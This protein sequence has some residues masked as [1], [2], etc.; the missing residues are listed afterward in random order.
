MTGQVVDLFAGPGGWDVAAHALGMDVI[1][2]ELDQA[3]CDTRR[4][5]GFNTLQASVADLDP[6]DFRPCDG[7]IAS[8][9][10]QA[11]SSAGKRGG[12][13][14]KPIV[15][16]AARDIVTGDHSLAEDLARCEDPRSLL[17]V[18]PLRWALALRPRWLAFEQV[19]PVLEFWRYIAEFLRAAGYQVWTGLLSSERY[20]VAQT[21]R[22]AIL[23]ASL[24]GPVAPPAPTHQAYV[25]GEPAREEITLEGVLEPWVSMAEAL[26][27]TGDGEVN[28]RRGGDR[29]DESVPTGGPSPTLTGRF[30]RWQVG[31]PRLADDGAATEDGYRE[32]DLRGAGEP[33][34]GM[35]E[36]V[37]SWTVIDTG[38]TSGGRNPGGARVRDGDEPA[39]PLTSRADQLE[40]RT[41]RTNNFSAKRRDLDGRR[42]QA[43]SEP[44]EREVDAPAPTVDTGAG[45]WKLRA[46][47][48]DHDAE[49]ADD[50]PAPTMR[51]GARLNTVEFVANA[52]PNA[53]RRGA[54]EP[55]PTITGGH[56]TANRQF[57]EA[58][59][60]G[61]EWP[62][63]RPATTVVGD[64][65]VFP[66]GH[67]LN[68]A[69]LRAGRKGQRRDGGDGR[70][71]SAAP[72]DD[73]DQIALAV[74]EFTSKPAPTITGSRRSKD[75][76]VVGRRLREGEGENVGG[77][78]WKPPPTHL[79]TR[80][81]HAQAREV[82]APSPAMVGQ[83]LGKGGAV[84]TDDPATEESAPG[85]GYKPTRGVRVSL[86]DA[87]VLQSFPA[88]YP[89]QGNRT[90]QFE[91]VGNAV[92]PLLAL[93]V[94]EAV[95]SREGAAGMAPARVRARAP[96]RR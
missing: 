83:N 87:A 8:P 13:R 78:G 29:I 48:N 32:R 33:A 91:Q 23:M 34:F 41:V 75:G 76:G 14:D 72:I 4:A 56:D 46:G 9:P 94:L 59:G 71:V 80:Q 37:R 7:L 61:Q 39:V 55:A 74:D 36:K 90:K 18:E 84:W 88:D 57:V 81:S 65:R 68:D 79:D 10:C 93:A 20:G 40:R 53:A 70:L 89:F 11:W 6:L 43:G 66:P 25:P 12:E 49:R 26:G 31:F 3:A 62:Q 47:T 60:D 52:Q 77:H 69:D 63:G 86:A 22:R 17:V 28:Y 19:P 73:G 35:T 95:A 5:A 21:R 92:P 27:W 30:D 45:G 42:T 51:F 50:E 24:D 16:R 44:Y 2:V 1:G 54:G 85:T 67:K 15:Y 96:G 58:D 64:P 82:T 38:C